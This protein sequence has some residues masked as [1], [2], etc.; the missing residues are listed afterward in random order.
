MRCRGEVFSAL[1]PL[2]LAPPSSKGEDRDARPG[3]LPVLKL[4]D[5]IRELQMETRRGALKCQRK[6]AK[7]KR[8]WGGRG[9]RGGE[10]QR[11]AD[12]GVWGGGFPPENLPS[13]RLVTLSPFPRRLWAPGR[14]L[15]LG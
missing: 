13:W 15:K 7:G 1:L 5:F 12:R 2:A 3:M 14:S 4:I 10:N 6:V 11:W 9:R 8:R